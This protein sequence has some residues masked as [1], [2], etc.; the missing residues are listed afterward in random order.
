[1]LEGLWL[2]YSTLQNWITPPSTPAQSKER[3]GSNFV[4]WQHLFLLSLLSVDMG[5]HLY[6]LSA[7]IFSTCRPGRRRRRRRRCAA[8]RKR[9]SIVV[10]VIVVAFVGGGGEKNGLF[11]GHAVQC[12]VAPPP[13]QYSAGP[14]TGLLVEEFMQSISS[15]VILV[16]PLFHRAHTSGFH[17]TQLLKV[18]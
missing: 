3:K 6:S 10:R 13:W 4:I 2:R 12:S 15:R 5:P 9:S 17:S 7:N 18:E 1:M 14:P 8:L 11:M 16:Q